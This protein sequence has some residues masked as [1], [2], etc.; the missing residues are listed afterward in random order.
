[1]QAQKE[2][3]SQA[4]SS[5]DGADIRPGA[6]WRAGITLKSAA[7]AIFAMM[8]LSMLIQYGEVVLSFSLPLA[9][10]TLALPAMWIALVL[11]GV[12]GISWSMAR[13]RILSRP[14]LLCVIYAMLV[15][16]PLMTQGFWHRFI[17][18][19]G[20][21]PRST[22]TWDKLD[23]FN[24]RLWPHGENLLA[25]ELNN[26]DLLRPGIRGNVVWQ[27][28]EYEAE[29]TENLPVMANTR[30]DEVSAVRLR[31]PVVP[32]DGTEAGIVRSEP[33]L[34][35]VLARATELAPGSK[36]YC[37]VYEDGGSKFQEIFSSES[38]P[39]VTALHQKGFQRLGAYGTKFPGT[40]EKYVDVELGL[41][42][43][44]RLEIADAKLM[45]VSTLEGIYKGRVIVRESNYAKLPEAARAGVVVKPDNMVSWSGLKFV[46]AGYIPLHD[47]LMPAAVWSSFL[48]LIMVAFLAVNALM[49]QQWMDSERYLMPMARVTQLLLGPDPD[50][51]GA[52][53]PI[54]KNGWMWAGGAIG[55]LW[56]LG[57]IWRHVNPVIP[58]VTVTHRMNEFF[59]SGTWG[60]MFDVNFDLNMF[61]ISLCLFMELNVLFS[62]ILGFWVFRTQYWI[63]HKYGWDTTPNFPLGN[64]QMLGSYVAYGLMIMALSWRYIGRVL[65]AALFNDKA[66]SNGELFSY[67]TSLLLLAACF[68]FGGIWAHWV[69]ISVLGILTFLAG[70]VLIGMVSS[71]LRTECGTPW[72]EFAVFNLALI[73]TVTGGIPVFGPQAMFFCYVVT[74]F[75]GP[76]TFFLIP[77]GQM[78]MI[79]LGRRWRVRPSHITTTL[80]LAMLGG[81]FLGGWAFLSNAYAL[82]GDTIK[83]GWAF[84]SKAWNFQP[85]NALMDQAQHANVLNAGPAGAAHHIDPTWYAY[86]YSAIVTVILTAM[87]QM[88]SWFWFH[89]IGFVVSASPYFGAKLWGSALVALL[90]RWFV[91]W[92]GGAA[93]IRNKLQPFAIGL[94]VGA[95][96]G[97]FI[98]VALATYFRAMGMADVYS[99]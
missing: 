16:A 35:S 52:S 74:F 26:A 83:Y 85:F 43:I 13:L 63:G 44:G 8:L 3:E 73:L 64:E 1:M 94:L 37:R 77:G 22:E 34:F 48:I 96:S 33:Y 40:L 95:L 24:D 4:R 50:A 99:G 56:T 78:E 30:S 84:D 2:Q 67:R 66:A 11:L 42:G 10:E 89:P 46:I 29:K 98:S 62:I 72:S 31:V 75:M 80:V 59:T 41:S 49:R 15:S 57:K 28:V 51:P 23:A 17:A 88:F 5:E 25:G 79:E 97:E 14:E 82:G 70:I 53:A 69:G 81:L 21:I 54:W 92:F 58:D 61:F 45:N 12:V 60:T 39:R 86:G 91:L 87:R 65:K 38:G 90:V 7:A 36:Y 93:T 6:T 47:W 20:T 68:G 18:I 76:T 9:E 71:K 27:P 55:L 32:R 19:T